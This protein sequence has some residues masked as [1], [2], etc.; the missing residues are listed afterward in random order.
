VVL[1]HRFA[2]RPRSRPRVRVAAEAY[3]HAPQ[4]AGLWP[5]PAAARSAAMLFWRVAPI[6]EPD[7]AGSEP[8]ARII[9]GDRSPALFALCDQRRGSRRA[10]G[11]GVR[12]CRPG[13][14]ASASRGQVGELGRGRSSGRRVAVVLLG[15]SQGLLQR[16]RSAVVCPQ[17]ADP[18]PA[19]THSRRESSDPRGSGCSACSDSLGQLALDLPARALLDS[20]PGCS[21]AARTASCRA[22]PTRALCDWPSRPASPRIS[23]P[24]RER[25]GAEGSCSGAASREA[26]G[27]RLR[28]LGGAMPGVAPLTAFP[29]TPLHSWDVAG[30]IPDGAVDS[31]RGVYPVE[32]SGAVLGVLQRLRG[33]WWEPDFRSPAFGLAVDAVSS[34][35]GKGVRWRP[36]RART[37]SPAAM[38]PAIIQRLSRRTCAGRASRVC[39]GVSISV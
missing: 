21:R 7:P 23:V 3:E 16:L 1:R 37:Q 8:R 24:A 35:P 6:V 5:P 15:V 9:D 26:S 4:A 11:A 2:S 25:S 19:F 30:V 33:T 17:R 31:R 32:A 20:R 18:A 38:L 14:G 36:V 10:T 34:L 29:G 39:V 13:V 22:P 28:F 27:R 12:S